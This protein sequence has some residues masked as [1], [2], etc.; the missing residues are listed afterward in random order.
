MS[1]SDDNIIREIPVNIPTFPLAHAYHSNLAFLPASP[2][3]TDL[4]L[5]RH[6]HTDNSYLEA[7]MEFMQGR[8][9]ATFHQLARP[10]S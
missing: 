9:W 8:H 4:L 1:G 3:T 2:T 5:L 10:S 6:G 7:G